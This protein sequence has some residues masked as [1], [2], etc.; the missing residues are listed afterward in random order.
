MLSQSLNELIFSILEELLS[1]MTLNEYETGDIII[2][3]LKKYE[4]R[5]TEVGGY[6]EAN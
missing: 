1:Y 4:D 2:A 6:I 5:I 3:I